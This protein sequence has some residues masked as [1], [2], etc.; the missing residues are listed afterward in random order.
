MRLFKITENNKDYILSAQDKV[1]AVKK[2]K[3]SM[4]ARDANTI[5]FNEYRDIK[6]SIPT[7]GDARVNFDDYRGDIEVTVSWAS[8]G[9]K[10]SSEAR[11]FVN[12][13]QNAIKYAEKLESKYLGFKVENK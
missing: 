3:D 7:F 6:R 5:T 8:L 11:K 9:G 12:E 10:S 1:D 13:L 4:L 2:L